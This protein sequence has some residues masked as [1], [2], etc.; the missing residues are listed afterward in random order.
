M[1]KLGIAI[2]GTGAVS[3][4]HAQGFSALEDCELKVLCDTNRAKAEQLAASLDFPVE[5]VT[6]YREL[7]AREDIDA[8]SICLP[9]ALHCKFTVLHGVAVY[10]LQYLNCL[11]GENVALLGALKLQVASDIAL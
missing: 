2:I 10:L 6:D 4:V 3:A 8:V 9:P 11:R 5:I 1:K 7:L